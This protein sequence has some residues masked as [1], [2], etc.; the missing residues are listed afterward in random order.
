MGLE[1]FF[2]GRD[3]ITLSVTSSKFKWPPCGGQLCNR[4]ALK[5]CDSLMTVEN[6]GAI[7]QKGDVLWNGPSNEEKLFM[8][9]LWTVK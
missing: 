3:V 9:K 5:S 7:A 1:S 4:A 8:S 2:L 6:V